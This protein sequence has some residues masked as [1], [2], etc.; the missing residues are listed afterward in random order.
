[1]VWTLV[2]RDGAARIGN[3]QTFLWLAH[4]LSAIY[5]V[6]FG[7]SEFSAAGGT[8]FAHSKREGSP[9]W[10]SAIR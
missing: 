8:G 10:C 9:A 4:P 6:V 7:L 3:V 5:S 2:G 1:M